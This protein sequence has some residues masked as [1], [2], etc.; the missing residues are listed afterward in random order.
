[1]LRTV[2]TIVADGLAPFEFGVICEG[3]GIDPTEDGVPPI[4]FLVCGEPPGTPIRTSAGASLTPDHGLDALDRAD[5]V[6]IPAIKI[7]D[8]YPPAIIDAVRRA[9]HRGS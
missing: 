5:L 7:R 2:A 8:G 1:M 4:E 6:T 9:H 3:F